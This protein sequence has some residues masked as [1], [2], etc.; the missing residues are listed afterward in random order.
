M[1]VAPDSL[2]RN[3][4]SFA[5]ILKPLRSIYGA[6][7]ATRDFPA[8]YI[9]RKIRGFSPR[10][11]AGSTPWKC[12]LLMDAAPMGRIAC[13]GHKRSPARE[14]CEP[15]IERRSTCAAGFTHRTSALSA[16]IPKK[17]P[18]SVRPNRREEVRSL[19]SNQLRI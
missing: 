5:M 9:T 6:S 2:R 7:L 17:I 4:I 15:G 19:I 12:K 3:A 14:V 13:R 10:N 8:L 18:P 16:S 11:M 1:A